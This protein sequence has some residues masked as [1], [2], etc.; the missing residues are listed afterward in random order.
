ML[1][2]IINIYKKKGYTSHD[3]VAK[4]RGILR[5]RK[6][7]HTGTLD[8]EAEGV[9]PLCIGGA[10]KA[11]PYLTE[12]D[13]CYEA[14]VILG[15]TTTTEDATGEI[16]QRYEVN[17]TKEQV[18]EV[19]SSF[20][21]DYIQTPPMYSAIKVNGV[22]L[23]ELARQG[24]VVERPSRQVKIY[25]CELIEWIDEKRFRIRVQCSK[26][27]YIRTLCTDIGEALGCGAHMGYLLRTKVGAF[28]LNESL[29][30]EELEANKENILPYIKN[31]D[32][33]FDEYPK[34][35]INE[36]GKNFL[37]N[38]NALDK[39]HLTEGLTLHSDELIR[40]YDGTRFIALYKW[41]S[42]RNH[43]EVERMFQ[44]F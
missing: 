35:T 5:E 9:L 36:L 39:K 33:L 25:A 17:V 1:N 29:T 34:V 15:E 44:T 19:I 23:Y 41:N 30:L 40:V 8:P 16:L 28:T 13:K 2:G 31:L 11:V 4:A 6:I 37:R 22:R 26:G 20:V 7:G 3:V 43:L 10:T 38:G 42:K 27:T 14:E 24:I 12:A 21:G 18:E 32:L